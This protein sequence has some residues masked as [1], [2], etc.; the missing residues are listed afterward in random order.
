MIGFWLDLLKR[1]RNIKIIVSSRPTDGLEKALKKCCR[2]VTQVENLPDVK[3]IVLAGVNMLKA[4]MEAANAKTEDSSSDDEPWRTSPLSAQRNSSLYSAEADK[5]IDNELHLIEKYLIDNAE[6]IILWV[7]TVLESVEDLCIEGEFPTVMEMKKELESIP[8]DLNKM[9]KKIL[10][11]LSKGKRRELSAEKAKRVL[12]WVTVATSR[13]QPLR[14]Q[15][16]LEVLAM[17][18]NTTP[19]TAPTIWIARVSDFQSFRRHMRKLLGPF[20]EVIKNPTDDT[21]AMMLYSATDRVQLLHQSVKTFLE[22]Q[23]SAGPLYFERDQAEALVKEE[24]SRYVDD[25]LQSS[26]PFLSPESNGL[27]QRVA[28]VMSYLEEKRLL[29]FIFNAFPE[30]QS[31]VPLRYQDIFRSTFNSPEDEAA[32]WL[33]ITAEKMFQ[34]A[35]MKGWTNAVV[36]IFNL[37]S[38]KFGLLQAEWYSLE[39]AILQGTLSAAMR[40]HQ[41]LSQIRIL[42]W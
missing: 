21:N 19:A 31:R 25:S 36:N 15:D 7:K 39:S 17:G 2:I 16:I 3:K 5:F 41:M 20:I 32:W 26:R 22:D 24:S 14:T 10:S 9:Y 27:D 4:A 30:T 18:D 28:S 8:P 42:R 38:M 29:H 12:M 6:D 23:S 33:E 35:C 1:R 34:L 37:A 13:G 40:F 11:G